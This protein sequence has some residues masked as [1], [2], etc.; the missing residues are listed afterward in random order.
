MSAPKSHHRKYRDDGVKNE[1]EVDNADEPQGDPS[2]VGNPILEVLADTR[3]DLST[4][5]VFR[6][7]EFN[8]G[9]V[10]GVV[11]HPRTARLA[12]GEVIGWHQ[13]PVFS[14]CVHVAFSTGEVEIWCD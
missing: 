6:G 14:T 9:H 5:N 1:Y 7:A 2:G 13:R 3:R 11:S 8:Q 12:P 10:Y 4:N